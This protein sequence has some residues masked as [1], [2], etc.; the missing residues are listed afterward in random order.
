MF[1]KI[2]HRIQNQRPTTF[3][4]GPRAHYIENEEIEWVDWISRMV[5]GRKHNTP[6]P[7]D[8]LF[9]AMDSG[10]TYI[11]RFIRVEQK[12]LT[13]FIGYMQDVG[14]DNGDGTA[15][16]HDGT[17]VEIEP[18]QRFGIHYQYERLN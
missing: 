16:T 4:P 7:G 8:Y 13:K 10:R 9:S 5:M 14:Y 18:D 12:E 2:V 6:I 3:E 11:F 1:S 17:T 15:T